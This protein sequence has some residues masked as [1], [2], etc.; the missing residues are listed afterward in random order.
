MLPDGV[1]DRFADAAEEL[2]DICVSEA[3][4][5]QT[6]ADLGETDAGFWIVEGG[7]EP[8]VLGVVGEVSE[9]DCR[10]MPARP[11]DYHVGWW[12]WE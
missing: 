7:S 4:I 12:G 2:A 8:H 6:N 10:W 3:V 9:R 11:V 1:Q 5:V